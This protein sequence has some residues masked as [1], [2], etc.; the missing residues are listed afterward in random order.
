MKRED[1]VFA[2]LHLQYCK[3]GNGRN[4]ERRSRWQTGKRSSSQDEY[5]LK[6][7][8]KIK[9]TRNETK[10]TGNILTNTA[11]MT[12]GAYFDTDI[13]GVKKEF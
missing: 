12:K 5:N 13:K 9:Y 8:S 6:K 10:N 3:T 4:G 2:T 1:A 7:G 11:L